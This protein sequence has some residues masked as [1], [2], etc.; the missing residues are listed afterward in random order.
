M[1]QKTNSI[2][3]RQELAEL[4]KRKAEIG[5]RILKYTKEKVYQNRFELGNSD[6]FVQ[7]F[8]NTN[9]LHTYKVLLM[10]LLML[11]GSPRFRKQRSL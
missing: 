9:H 2:D 8:V 4:V 3:A 1:A 11:G 7:F 6:C 10:V 5:V